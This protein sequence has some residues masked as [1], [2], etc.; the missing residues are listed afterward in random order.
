MWAEEFPGKRVFAEL[1]CKKKNIIQKHQ[2]WTKGENFGRFTQNAMDATASWPNRNL[3]SAAWRRLYNL[4]V[5]H[6]KMV[7]YMKQTHVRLD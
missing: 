7:N 6:S 4:F 2:K 5:E 1:Q 3:Q